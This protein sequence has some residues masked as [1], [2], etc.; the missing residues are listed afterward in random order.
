MEKK[1]AIPEFHNIGW[2]VVHTWVL[3][4]AEITRLF[5]PFPAPHQVLGTPNED[6]WPGVHALPHFKPGTFQG[7]Q[8]PSASCVQRAS[9]PGTV[10]TEN[11][12]CSRHWV[13]APSTHAVPPFAFTPRL[14]VKGGWM[15]PLREMAITHT[16]IAASCRN[17]ISSS[18]NL[19]SASVKPNV[20][21]MCSSGDSVWRSFKLWKNKKKEMPH[22]D[23][24]YK[25][26]NMFHQLAF[27]QCRVLLNVKY[28]NP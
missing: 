18:V 11:S 25:T 2:A 22:F 13:L 3:S 10:A 1:K 7:L 4:A 20:K 27:V 9:T 26:V 12:G 28:R 15:A 19:E 23:L 24:L 6:T 8:A 14:S 21:W 17:L 5:L 16:L